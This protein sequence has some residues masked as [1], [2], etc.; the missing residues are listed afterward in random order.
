MLGVAGARVACAALLPALAGCYGQAVER[1]QREVAAL[2][3]DVSRLE[4]DVRRMADLELRLAELT[5]E[6]RELNDRLARRGRPAAAAPPEARTL[7]EPR[8]GAVA[9]GLPEATLVE[10]AGDRGKRRSL[11]A[12]VRSHG[13]AVVSFWATWCK[14]CV[15]DEELELLS[16]LQRRLRRAGSDLV[17]VA[18]DDL[19]DVRSSPRADRWL[20][21]LWH[22]R[23]GHLEMLPRRF[24]EEV[25]VSLPLFL[26]VDERGSIRKYHRAKLNPDIVRELAEAA[27]G[28]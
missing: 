21:P 23:D 9:L 5:T 26:V 4:A 8:G 1:N 12:H 28:P 15:A 10:R 3:T 18:V 6:V 20:Y 13:G 17:S 24:M 25:G 2:R 14:P 16:D 11:A 27:Q 19:Q 7:R 22:R